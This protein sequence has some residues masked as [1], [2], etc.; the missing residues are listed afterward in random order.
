MLVHDWSRTIPADPVPW[1]ETM[2][3]ARVRTGIADPADP[4]HGF[5]DPAGPRDKAMA[6]NNR[7]KRD[8]Y[9][10]L[11]GSVFAKHGTR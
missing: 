1:W 7:R 10:L 2:A 3:G 5:L 8:T 4:A 11:R 9:C 6:P